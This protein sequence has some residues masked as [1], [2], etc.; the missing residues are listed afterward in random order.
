MN[1]SFK[2]FLHFSR[3]FR[4]II[5]QVM[6]EFE[7]NDFHHDQNLFIFDDYQNTHRFMVV[8]LFFVNGHLSS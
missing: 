8:Y 2:H 6:T 5:F 4:I 7:S 1:H 3:C